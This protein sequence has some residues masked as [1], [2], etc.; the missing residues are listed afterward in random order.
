MDRETVKFFTGGGKYIGFDDPDRLYDIEAP[1][2][3]V[4]KHKKPQ[5][6][7]GAATTQPIE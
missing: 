3:E 6:L 1:D 4:V 7:T 2:L 5:G